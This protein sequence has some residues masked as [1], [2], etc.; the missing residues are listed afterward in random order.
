MVFNEQAGATA[1]TTDSA[2]PDN[3]F[4]LNI[5]LTAYRTLRLGRARQ[6]ARDLAQ[7]KSVL[8]H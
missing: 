7:G 1:R 2:N 4:R 5:N 8:Q 3:N 6:A